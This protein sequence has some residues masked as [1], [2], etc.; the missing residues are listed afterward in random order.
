MQHNDFEKLDQTVEVVAKHA[1]RALVALDELRR[2]PDPALRAAY[3][4]LHDLLGDLGGLRAQL[5]AM[6]LLDSFDLSA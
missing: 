6:H 4:E 5:G 3:G 2:S 1:C